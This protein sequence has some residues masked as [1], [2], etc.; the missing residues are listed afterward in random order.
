MAIIPAS[1]API[2]VVK[3]WTVVS[4]AE[5]KFWS[6]A[7]ARL[8]TRVSRCGHVMP[9]PKPMIAM[10]RQIGSRLVQCPSL[11][12][13]TR[14]ASVTMPAIP[15]MGAARITRLTLLPVTPDEPIEPSVQLP[16]MSAAR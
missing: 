15:M 14:I 13:G 4:D 12:G 9:T 11:P 2:A 3:S 16:P 10:A 8:K 6:A 1:A 5:A 7:S